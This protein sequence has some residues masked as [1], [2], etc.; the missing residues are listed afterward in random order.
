MLEHFQPLIDAAA[1]IDLSD[2]AAAVKTLNE[3][4]DPGSEEAAQVNAALEELL[5]KGEIANNGELPVQWSR[6]CK[7]TDES[8]DLSIDVVRMTGPGPRHRHPNGE[9]NWCVARDGAPTFDG[10]GPGWVVHGPDTTHVPTVAGGEMLIVYL[11]PGGAIEFL[12]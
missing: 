5:A 2:P 3:R 7:A 8:R 6:V 9:M 4:F 12:K 1:G 10:E 11:L